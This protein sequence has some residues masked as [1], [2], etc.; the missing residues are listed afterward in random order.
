MVRTAGF[1]PPILVEK[2]TVNEEQRSKEGR[3]TMKE[4]YVQRYI[5]NEYHMEKQIK[6]IEDRAG[7]DST[8]AKNLKAN[9]KE[10]QEFIKDNDLQ[11]VLRANYTRTAFQI[12]GDDRVRISLDTNLAFI[13]E[14][15]IDTDR[16]CRDPE[17]WHRTDI[18]G[19]P[20]EYPF[21]S[22]RKGEISRFPFALLEI[23]IKTESKRSEWIKDLMNSHLI[24]EAPRFS[25]F[26]HG[27]SMLFEDYVNTFPFWL[28]EM[29]ADIRRDPH[30]L[31]KK[32]KRSCGRKSG[33]I[34]GRLAA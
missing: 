27:V 6:R 16:P 26:V 29:E 11:P 33:M 4:K 19:P 23:K 24:K 28:S 20:L 31:S 32:S 17:S 15:A 12:P 8:E 22:I 21:T 1:E 18:D 34:R 13:R 9:V 25:K 7:A 14:D 3:F 10:I 30:Q 5:K 2:K